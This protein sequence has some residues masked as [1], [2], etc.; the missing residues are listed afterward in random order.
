MTVNFFLYAAV[1]MSL[2]S[3]Q[4][5]VYHPH[6][7]NEGFNI[8]GYANTLDINSGIMNLYN[9]L[10]NYDRDLAESLLLNDLLRIYGDPQKLLGT[11][12][13]HLEISTNG[14]KPSPCGFIQNFTTQIREIESRIDSIGEYYRRAIDNREGQNGNWR[15]SVDDF[16]TSVMKGCGNIGNRSMCFFHRAAGNELKTIRGKTPAFPTRSTH[17][18]V[19]LS[20]LKLTIALLKSYADEIVRIRRHSSWTSQEK[21]IEKLQTEFALRAADFGRMTIDALKIAPKDIIPRDPYEHIEGLTFIRLKWFVEQIIV[22][23]ANLNK[24]ASCWN[25]CNDYQVAEF[26]TYGE[27]PFQGLEICHGVIHK[28]Y[29]QP[30]GQLCYAAPHMRRR[31]GGIKGVT[32]NLNNHSVCN[33][34]VRNTDD[35]YWI[36]SS[37][38]DRCDICTCLCDDFRNPLTV[39]TFSLKPVTSDVY[40]NMVIT[41]L[42]F[43][44]MRGVI[45]IEVQEARLMRQGAIDSFTRRWIPIQNHNHPE[46]GLTNDDYFTMRYVFERS[47]SLSSLSSGDRYVREVILKKSPHQANYSRVLTGVRLSRSNVSAQL[48]IGIRLTAVHTETGRLIRDDNWDGW[49]YPEHQGGTYEIKLE[50]PDIPI[51]G[52]EVN[53]EV[54]GDGRYVSFQPSDNLKDFGQTTVPFL[55][56]QDVVAEPPIPLSGAGLYFK[57]QKGYGGFIGLKLMSFDFSEFVTTELSRW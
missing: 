38:F 19:Y 32:R 23:E 41:G 29:L 2:G 35:T 34:G 57:G 9:Q 14:A 24:D 54:R 10:H 51:Y 18:E 17:Q 30:L 1:V 39:R 48:V 44:E 25:K 50:E 15:Q 31:Y 20:Y 7:I 49:V 33:Q 55:D 52:P 40:A 53:E 28:C 11:C 4:G 47:V 12:D 43:K 27:V 42:R 36:R 26:K 6:I 13:N 3:C 56:S 5:Q 16:Y 37:W 8:L 45:H 46:P 21:Q 22:N